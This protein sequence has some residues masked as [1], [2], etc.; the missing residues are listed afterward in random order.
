M[1][2]KIQSTVPEDE[3][4]LCYTCRF[5]TV[6]TGRN[7]HDQIV[8]CLRLYSSDSRVRFAVARCT[9]YVDRR[10]PSLKDFEDIALLLRSNAAHKRAGFR[11]G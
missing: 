1:H 2:L 8:E 3:S 7:P 9:G 11:I 6:V 4:S 10:R 5:A